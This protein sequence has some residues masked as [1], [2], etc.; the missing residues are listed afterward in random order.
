MNEDG[1]KSNEDGVKAHTGPIGLSPPSFTVIAV[2][3]KY[4]MYHH[5]QLTNVFV[6]C[7]KRMRTRRRCFSSLA[8]VS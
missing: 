2:A 6:F 5:Q 3:R 1:G 4:Y 7:S 8:C